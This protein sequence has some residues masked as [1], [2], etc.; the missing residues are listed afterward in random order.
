MMA[1]L[2]RELAANGPDR[3]TS[4]LSRSELLVKNGRGS[5]AQEPSRP[6]RNPHPVSFLHRPACSRRER[7]HQWCLNGRIRGIAKGGDYKS[8]VFSFYDT[9][10]EDLAVDDAAMV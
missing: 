2:M 6:D 4:T 5:K 1:V 9:A 8:T 10:G 3:P 7:Q